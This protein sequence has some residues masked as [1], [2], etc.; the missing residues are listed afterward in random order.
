M[1]YVKINDQSVQVIAE[2]YGDEL[3]TKCPLCGEEKELTLE[4][5]ADIERQ[6]DDLAGTSYY[7]KGCL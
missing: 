4:E 1:I 3:F 2:F 6:G 7:C 5:V